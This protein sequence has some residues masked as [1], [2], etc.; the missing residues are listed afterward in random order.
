[1]REP[2]KKRID[3]NPLEDEGKEIG[4]NLGCLRAGNTVSRAEMAFSVP[5]C[6]S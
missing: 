2:Q 4:A 5:C 1:M 6:R 3:P